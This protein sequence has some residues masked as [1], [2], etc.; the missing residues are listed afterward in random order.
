MVYG[1]HGDIRYRKRH[2]EDSEERR[3]TDR[4]TETVRGRDR[5]GDRV[6][7]N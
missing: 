2:Y 5:D 6:G 1:K 4:E 3:Q 7:S